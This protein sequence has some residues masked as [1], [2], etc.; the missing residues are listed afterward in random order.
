MTTV[1]VSSENSSL[2]TWVVVQTSNGNDSCRRVVGGT[3]QARI[4]FSS[5]QKKSASSVTESIVH[6]KSQFQTRSEE[7]LIVG[8]HPQD[9]RHW[10]VVV[11]RGSVLD[12]GNSTSKH[13]ESGMERENRT[14]PE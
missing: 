8:H 5:L 12:V 10:R 9:S 14:L 11:P 4:E 2:F 7:Q 1:V 3:L 13:H 6:S